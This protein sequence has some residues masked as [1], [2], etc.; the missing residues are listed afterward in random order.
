[1]RCRWREGF[2]R[3]GLVDEVTLG[4]LL[5]KA[6]RQG[7]RVGMLNSPEGRKGPGQATTDII[8]FSQEGETVHSEVGGE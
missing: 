5:G 8:E 4:G 7:W 6:A 2:G 1:M 3:W